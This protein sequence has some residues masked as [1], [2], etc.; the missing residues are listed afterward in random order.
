MS[1]AADGVLD[2]LMGT[3]FPTAL[4]SFSDLQSGEG[5]KVYFGPGLPKFTTPV[6]LQCHG[7]KFEMDWAEIGPSYRYEEVASI[8]C[9]LTAWNPGE[10]DSQGFLNR[11]TECFDALSL[12]TVNI[13][14]DYTLGSLVRWTRFKMGQLI[15]GQPQ[16]GSMAHLDFE[17]CYQVRVSSLTSQANVY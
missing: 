7:I 8:P 1:A 17:L 2:Y 11:K 3:T 14:N 12:I 9:T 4:S 10:G 16:T 13:G 5:C 6:T 15:P